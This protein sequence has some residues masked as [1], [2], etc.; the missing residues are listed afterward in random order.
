[1]V[2]VATDFAFLKEK[3]KIIKTNFSHCHD[4]TKDHIIIEFDFKLLA[5]RSDLLV[6]TGGKPVS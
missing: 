6:F 4:A 2:L 5:L 1:M 3:L